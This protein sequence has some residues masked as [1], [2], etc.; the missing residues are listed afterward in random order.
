MFLYTGSILDLKVIVMKRVIAYLPTLFIVTGILLSSCSLLVPLKVEPVTGNFGS[1]YTEKD[2]QTRTFEVLWKDIQDSYINYDTAKINWNELHDKYQAQI[3]SGLTAE[4]FTALLQGLE[5]DLPAGSVVY[6]S[7]ADRLQAD[8]GDTSIYEG[9]GAFIGF[10]AK[11]KPHIVILDVIKGSPAESAGLKAHDSIFS[12]DGSPILMEEGLEASN[13][14]RGPAGSSVTLDV[15]TPG[16]P[17]RSVE[18]DRAKLTTTGKLQVYNITDTDFG[19]ILFPPVGYTGLDKDVATGLQTMA[20]NRTLKGLILDLRIVNSSTDW[21]VD[22]LLTMFN[23]GKIGEVFN[24]KQTQPLEIQGQ[25]VLGSQTMPLII[26]VGQNT[27]GFAEIFAASLQ[28]SQRVLVVGEPTS[29]EVETQT[30]FYLPD[31]SRVFIQSTSFRLSNGDDLGNSGVKPDVPVAAS[32]DQILPNQD[33]VLDR[34][35]E[36]IGSLP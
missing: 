7:R 23:N 29:G 9:I 25:D 1:A 11:A 33:P 31:G 27:K 13:R 22:T 12:I 28:G 32:W 10:Q 16:R 19:Y 30:A 14:I 26:L 21:P 20:T 36:I 6:Q 8:M 24:R 2:H 15:K 3:D 4:Q 17:E 35:I 34:A 5:T 18:V